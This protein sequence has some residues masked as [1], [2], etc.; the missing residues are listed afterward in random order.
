MKN[1]KTKVSIG[2]LS[3]LIIGSCIVYHKK[4]KNK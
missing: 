2:L 4:S 1:K 3:C